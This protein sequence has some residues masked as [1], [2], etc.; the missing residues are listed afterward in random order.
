MIG[1]ALRTVLAEHELVAREEVKEEPGGDAL[2][3]IGKAMVLRDEVE[4]IRRLFLR[5]RIEVF[6]ARQQFLIA[7]LVA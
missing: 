7:T 1:D 2:V 4:Q 6:P 5:R 3:A